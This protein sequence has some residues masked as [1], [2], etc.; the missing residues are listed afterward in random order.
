VLVQS[1]VDSVS[2]GSVAAAH[3]IAL[4]RGVVNTSLETNG[5]MKWQVSMEGWK[6]HM[7][8]RR[9]VAAV[10]RKHRS[11]GCDHTSFFGA[12]IR[13]RPFVTPYQAANEVGSDKDGKAPLSWMS[14]FLL[15]GSGDTWM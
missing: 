6:A 9:H 13:H 12:T 4:S 5:G 10:T 11:I 8:G 2:A 14:A 1:G 15:V 3:I 7:N